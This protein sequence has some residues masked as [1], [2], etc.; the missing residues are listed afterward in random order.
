MSRKTRKLIWSVPLMAAIA[1]VGAL[2]LFMT[3]QPDG[4]AAQTEEQIPGAPIN[5]TA[6]GISPTSIELTWDPPMVGDGGDPDFYRIDHSPDGLVWYSLD[7][8][9]DSTIYTDDNGLSAIETRHYRVFAVNSSGTSDVLGP[10]S[11]TTERSTVPKAIEDLTATTKDPDAVGTPPSPHQEVIR[12]DWTAPDDP[13]GAPVTDYRIQVSKDGKSFS[14]LETVTAKVAGCDADVSCEYLHKDLLESTKRWYRVYTIN[15]M[16]GS[17]ASSD[18]PEGSTALGIAPGLVPGVRAGLNPAGKIFLY[19]DPPV[20]EE[21]EPGDQ[22]DPEGAPILGYYIQGER[23]T[24]DDTAVGTLSDTPSKEKLVYVG[25]N[26]DVPITGTLQK[27]LATSGNTGTQ[28]AFRVIAANR[29]VDRNLLGGNLNLAGDGDANPSALLNFDAAKDDAAVETDN[30]LNAPTLKV[31]RDT[32][33][34]GGRVSLILDWDVDGAVTTGTVTT[35]RVEHSADL[36]DWELIHPGAADGATGTFMVDTTDPTKGSHDGLVAGTTHHYRVFATHPRGIVGVF[37]EA[38]RDVKQ[39]TAGAAQPDPP[40]LDDPTGESET[41]IAMAWTPPV[42]A[43]AADTTMSAAGLG[44]VGYGRITGYQIYSS[45]DG[46]TFTPLVKVGP[47]LNVTYSYNDKTGALIKKADGDDT[48]VDFEHTNLVQDQTVHYR[49]STINNASARVQES[50]ASFTKSATTRRSQASDDPGGLVVK[51]MGSTAIKLL[52]NARADDITAAEITGY[53]IESS[54]LKADDDCMEDW[55]VLEEDTISTATSYTHG[56]LAAGTGQCYRVFGINVV[57]T[58]TSFVGYGDAYVTTNDNDAIAITDAAPPNTAPTAGAA[59]ADQ[60]VT[61]GETVMV[62]STITE[63]DMGDTLS[64]DATSDMTMYATAEVDDMGM[65]T[66]TGVAAGTA[67]ITVTATDSMGAMATQEIMVTV[68]AAEPEEVGPATGVT[69]GPFNEGGVI[70]VNW[71]PAPNATGYIIYAVNV[72][73]LN[74]P[75]GQIVVAPVNDAA[76]ETYNLGGLKSGDTYDIYVVATAK[77]MVA[78]PAD[79]D[80]DQVDAE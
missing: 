31:S 51:S 19:W 56:G 26:T 44:P 17:A 32:N 10:V 39:T 62:Q 70:Q 37:T 20:D 79:A 3:L 1:V 23:G 52:W 36:V 22:G 2:A 42:D 46:T 76:A 58:S 65:V 55:T 66:I 48:K 11:G 15:K 77:E 57:A 33:N 60:T 43:D 12:L 68:E 6:E 64:W 28:W 8:S 47:K 41:I 25:A 49:V 7:P 53:R 9:Y 30:L 21:N 75:D 73:E 34:V 14:N 67:T 29:V 63:S 38:S 4:A 72:D 71:D 45:S 16:G 35:Y 24:I 59:I 61:A 18:A 13:D 78:W 69:T 54:P 50:D 27:Q 5:L 74:N 80:V 40:A